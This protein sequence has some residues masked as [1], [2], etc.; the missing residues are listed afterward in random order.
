MVEVP[1]AVELASRFLREV[2]FLSI[3]TNDLIQYILA[4]DRSNRKVASL[5]EPL[6][7]AVLSALNVTIEAGKREGKR[8]G[9]CGEMAGDPLCAVLLL[10]MGLEE[11]SMGSL[12]IPVI[13]KAIRSI[14][15]QTAKA[16]AQIVLEMDTMGEIKRYLF[17]Q[18]RDLG[19]VELLEM[20]H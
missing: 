17:E 13:K 7:P 15:Y 19:M 4:V 3:G 2:D 5:Y 6:H 8:V 20:Y 16:T 9:M 10:G 11:F 1:A 18:M 14:S 12:Y